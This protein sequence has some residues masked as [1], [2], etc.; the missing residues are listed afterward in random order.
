MD[1]RKISLI[2]SAALPHGIGS[3]QQSEILELQVLADAGYLVREDFPSATPGG[4][5]PAPRYRATA[6][7]LAFLASLPAE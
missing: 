4:P 7:G 6:F 2:R 1:E 5:I 3:R